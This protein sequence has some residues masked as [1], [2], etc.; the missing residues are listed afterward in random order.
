[1]SEA[2]GADNFL[3]F[4]EEELIPHIDKTYRTKNFRILAGPQAAA[5]FSLYA[6]IEK[7][8]LFNAIISENPFMNPE[9][10]EYLFP[11]AEQFFNNTASLNHFLYITAVQLKFKK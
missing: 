4:L 10:A 2:G 6:L 5:V 1:L 9:N 8:K 7:P 3:R 11:R